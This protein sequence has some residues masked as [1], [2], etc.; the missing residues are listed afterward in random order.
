[1]VQLAKEDAP[2]ALTLLGW[3]HETG[4]GTPK[5]IPRSRE[6]YG[7]AALGS[8]TAMNNLG[9]LFEAGAVGSGIRAWR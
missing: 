7:A 2:S 5:D 8:A 1:M 6:L 3:M 9:A 4:S